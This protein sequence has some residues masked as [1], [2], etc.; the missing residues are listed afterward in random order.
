MGFF[1]DLVEDLVNFVWS[2]KSQQAIQE[3]FEDPGGDME[4]NRMPPDEQEK[5]DES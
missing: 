1:G 4:A 2:K 5:N 3:A